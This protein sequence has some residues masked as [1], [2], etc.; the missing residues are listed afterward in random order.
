MAI[1]SLEAVP[2][3]KV[4]KVSYQMPT[5]ALANFGLSFRTAVLTTIRSMISP[6]IFELSKTFFASGDPMIVETI[7][8]HVT[9]A[10]TLGVL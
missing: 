10:E 6:G 7:G 5:S 2:F 3:F 4:A 9:T 1:A 8:F